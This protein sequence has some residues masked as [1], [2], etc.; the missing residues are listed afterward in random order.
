M[1]AI[2]LH[3]KLHVRYVEADDDDEE[4]L[5]NAE[6]KLEM[7][8]AETMQKIKDINKLEN[9]DKDLTLYEHGENIKNNQEKGIA[10]VLHNIQ[11]SMIILWYFRAR[12]IGHDSMCP[13]NRFTVLKRFFFISACLSASSSVN[14][15][16][17]F[18][19]LVIILIA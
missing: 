15:F 14:L 12:V 13:L 5:E 18:E 19:W 7:E 16:E 8:K 10:I 6:E 11:V 3:I 17:C 2:F 4:V 1:A 9:R